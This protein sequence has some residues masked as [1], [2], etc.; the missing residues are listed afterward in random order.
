MNF[1][2]LFLLVTLNRFMA[3]QKLFS[4]EVRWRGCTPE[5]KMTPERMK[6]GT[7]QYE[8]KEMAEIK[9]SDMVRK[10]GKN[11]RGHRD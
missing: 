9:V 1:P 4:S 3:F 11:Y 7:P 8:N 2:S 5:K 10:R 6:G